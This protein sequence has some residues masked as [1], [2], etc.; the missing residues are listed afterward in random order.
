MR[1]GAEAH[2]YMDQRPCS[3][4][5]IEFER[6]SAVMIDGGMLCGRYDGKCR[7]CG[8]ARQFIFELP[9]T[10]RPITNRLEFG[11]PDPSRL[12]DAGEWMAVSQYYA[13]LHPGTPED[14]EI[15]LAALEEVIKFLPDGVDSVPEKGF[16]TDRGRAVR[17]HEPGRF[18]RDRLGAVVD[19]YRK[20]AARSTR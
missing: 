4:G 10:Q 11:G 8:A 2:I 3:C 17:D 7:S 1:T 5:D 13:K 19:T 9:P 12:L 6:E 18:R 16:W 14:L 20:L 15:A